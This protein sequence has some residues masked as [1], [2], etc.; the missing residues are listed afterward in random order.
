MRTFAIVISTFPSLA[1]AEA[2]GVVVFLLIAGIPIL[3][4]LIGLSILS[5][6]PGKKNI[7]N[8]DISEIVGQDST[9]NGHN[10]KLT[11]LKIIRL[12]INIIKYVVGIYLALLP[13][14]IFPNS[15]GLHVANISIV[16]V[17]LLYRIKVY[18]SDKQKTFNQ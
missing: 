10:N 9:V 6:A 15:T 1:F 14:T 4:A 12:L 8:D 11:F 7:Q 3:L 17:I 18:F 13:I 2:N 5:R 16:A